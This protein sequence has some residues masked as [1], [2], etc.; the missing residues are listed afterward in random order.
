MQ[1]KEGIG[2]KVVIWSTT[3]MRAEAKA[4]EEI[5]AHIAREGLTET[6]LPRLH[7]RGEL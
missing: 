7:T 3:S 6:L 5:Y 1:R 2:F 4:P